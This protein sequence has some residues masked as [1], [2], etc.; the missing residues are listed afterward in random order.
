MRCSLDAGEFHQ[1]LNLQISKTYFSLH[2][3]SGFCLH[4][5]GYQFRR[6]IVFRRPKTALQQHM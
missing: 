2:Q 5:N 6:A 4:L 3:A 1:K